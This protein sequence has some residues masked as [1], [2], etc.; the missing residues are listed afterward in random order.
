MVKKAPPV[1]ERTVSLKRAISGIEGFQLWSTVERPL[2]LQTRITSFNRAL[3]CGGIPGGML[4]VIHGP[5]QGGKTLLLAE[6]LASASRAN[7]WSLFVDAECRG[8][9]IAWF[10]TIC[11]DLE[12]VAYFKPKTYEQ[13]IER[14]Q[15]FRTKFRDAKNA[16]GIPPEAFLAIGIDSIN[17][18]TPSS[19]L[20]DLLKGEV[21]GRK[22]PLRA[23]LTSSWLDTLIPTLERD[24]SF[25]FIQRESIRM[26][27]MPGQKKYTVKGGVASIY[28]GGWIGRVTAIQTVKKE[29]KKGDDE[30]TKI[31]EKHEIEVLKNSMGPHLD[32]L[33]FFYS[34]VGAEDE[35]PLG[36]D[37]VR[38][39]REESLY[40]GIVRYEKSR[41]YFMGEEMLGSSKIEFFK[42]LKKERDGVENWQR[43]AADLNKLPG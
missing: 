25:V 20:T 6:I 15:V 16:G 38:E 26:N 2:I 31:G 42:W 8:V 7:G 28:D 32:E 33:A 29:T 36:L 41:G 23:L 19:E 10:K 22:Y 12:S 17:R 5:S 27:A 37:C 34:S 39:V 4:G 21:E 9:D 13:A 35:T 18:L 11:A 40:R 24:E 30:K 1:G 14:I 3:R 43:L